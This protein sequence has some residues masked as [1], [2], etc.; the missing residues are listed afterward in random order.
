MSTV[1]SNPSWTTPIIEYLEHDK[2]L[3]DKNEA[4][5]VCAKVA[6]FSIIGGKLYKKSFAGPYLLCVRASKVKS[7]LVD[8]HVKKCENHSRSRSLAHQ[9]I[10][11]G[12]Y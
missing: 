10:T 9:V 7:I 1:D 3:I 2:L 8:L 4:K 12:Y 5:K 11:A 6:K